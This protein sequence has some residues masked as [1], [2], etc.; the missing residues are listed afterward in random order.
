MLCPLS[1]NSDDENEHHMIKGSHVLYLI[2]LNIFDF[3]Q[4][5]QVYISM[6]RIFLVLYLHMLTPFIDKLKLVLLLTNFNLL[7]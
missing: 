1:V 6:Y 7:T 3:F 2:V 4:L 5:L